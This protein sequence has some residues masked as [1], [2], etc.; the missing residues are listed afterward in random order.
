M[1]LRK[2]AL[3]SSPK[4]FFYKKKLAVRKLIE[5]IIFPHFFQSIKFKLIQIKLLYL[6]LLYIPRAE[7]CEIICKGLYTSVL[8]HAY[9]F[10]SRIAI[11]TL[12][13]LHS[14]TRTCTFLVLLPK[15]ITNK[16]EVT[17]MAKT[18]ILQSFHVNK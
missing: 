15:H 1:R 4:S 16:I 12:L 6:K 2:R 8:R 11:V 3:L 9:Q 17:G 13:I 5:N 18:Y 14:H 7:M 10:M